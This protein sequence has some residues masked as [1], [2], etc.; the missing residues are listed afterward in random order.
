MDQAPEI[1]QML[2][3]LNSLVLSLKNPLGT[4]DHP[5]H[6][7]RD[8]IT[9]QHKFNDGMFAC[10]YFNVQYLVYICYTDKMFLHI[11]LVN[12]AEYET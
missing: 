1:L 12:D 5:A 8:L 11:Q 9:C 6:L 3:Y 4:R 10:V 2:H 7:C